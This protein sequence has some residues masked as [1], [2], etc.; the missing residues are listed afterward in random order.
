M[1]KPLARYTYLSNRDNGF[2]D[3]LKIKEAG[4]EGS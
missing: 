1:E 3:F 2:H 4:L